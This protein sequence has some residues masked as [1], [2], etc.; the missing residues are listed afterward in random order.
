VSAFVGVMASLSI[1]TAACSTDSGTD[2]TVADPAPAAAETTSTTLEPTTTTTAPPTTTT[3]VPPPPVHRPGDGGL[4]ILALEQRLAELGYRPG[5]VD[6]SYTAATASAVMAYQKHEGLGRD[7]MA[8]P[9]TMGAVFEPPRGGGPTVVGAGP[10]L[11][12]DLDRQIMFV[13]LADGSVSIVN[14]SSG[15]NETYR[16]PAGYT[17]VAST[18]VGTFA[19]GRKIDAPE[20]AP[21]GT[22][23]RPMYFKGGFAVHGSTSVPGFPASHG[24][25]RTSYTDQD[26]LFPQIPP[27]TRVVVTSGGPVLDPGTDLPAA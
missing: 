1:V 3:T 8:G 20:V 26:W 16:H 7:G 14:V 17:A 21:L 2:A 25:V 6:G 12:I 18:P 9:Q 22:L 24:C 27:G 10:T 19:V 5:D 11:E 13:T 15:N 23:Y 4:E